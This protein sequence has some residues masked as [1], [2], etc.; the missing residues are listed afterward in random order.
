[1]E[2]F[3]LHDNPFNPK[4]ETSEDVN[5]IYEELVD[6]NPIHSEWDKSPQSQ[7]GFLSA[8]HKV[9]SP[10]PSSTP[11]TSYL[12]KRR[13]SIPA[14]ILINPTLSS[15]TAIPTHY[16]AAMS[17]TNLNLTKSL[18]PHHTCGTNRKRRITTPGTMSKTKSTNSVFE[19]DEGCFDVEHLSKS[20]QFVFITTGP[21]II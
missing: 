15:S 9:S 8:Q 13:S 3:H 19:C 16:P 14:R 2:Q 1:M 12:S 6:V 21:M 7:E 10:T 5:P 20:Q 11:S 17:L 4:Q 18:S